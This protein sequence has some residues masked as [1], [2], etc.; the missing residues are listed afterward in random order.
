MVRAEV[1]A[2]DDHHAA[3]NHFGRLE[4]EARAAIVRER[5]SG[6][7]EQHQA[8]RQQA[9][10]QPGCSGDDEGADSRPPRSSLGHGVDYGD[11]VGQATPPPGLLSVQWMRC[12]MAGLLDA[13]RLGC[14]VVGQILVEDALGGHPAS[15][16]LV[17][18]AAAGGEVIGH[19]FFFSRCLFSFFF[20]FFFFFFF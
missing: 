4:D 18:V 1:L 8:T 13:T 9:D 16:V 15:E 10:G 11:P 14:D 20:F 5:R 6:S 7:H 17:A 2:A 3:G 19:V 12:W